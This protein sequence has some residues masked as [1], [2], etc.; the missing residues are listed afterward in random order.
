MTFP[1]YRV[2]AIAS[3]S[4]VMM[5]TIS[6]HRVSAAPVL[7]ALYDPTDG[8]IKM[9]ALDNGVPANLSIATFQ[10]LSPALY[11]SGTAASIPA[12]A[13]SL[14]TVLNTAVSTM[15]NPS[16]VHAEI[17][18]TN[19]GGGTA[20]F[21]GTWDLGDVAATGLTQNQINLGFT[22]DADVS[23]GNQPLPGQFLYQVQGDSAFY[24]GQITAVPEPTTLLLAATACFLGC[25]AAVRRKTIA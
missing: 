21:T 6:A 16:S 5:A 3:L 22:T 4:M 18:A 12:P 7:T 19:L 15:V 13:A 23:P 11:L 24:A 20:L 14:F 2:V 8:N 1:L 17:Y 25:F 9:Q 10:F